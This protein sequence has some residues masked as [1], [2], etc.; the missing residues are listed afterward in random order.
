MEILKHTCQVVLNDLAKEGQITRTDPAAGAPA[1][2]NYISLQVL[3]A[4]V[5][6]TV[7]SLVPVL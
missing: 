5:P 2:D 1:G 6:D 7:L 4:H 3:S